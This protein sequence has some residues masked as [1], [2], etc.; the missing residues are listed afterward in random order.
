MATNNDSNW[1]TINGGKFPATIGEEFIN[2]WG[3]WQTDGD[4]FKFNDY[5]ATWQD[6]QY[7]GSFRDYVGI[8]SIG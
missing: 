7:N 4:G 8:C 1:V 3:K 5:Q 2:T 6:S